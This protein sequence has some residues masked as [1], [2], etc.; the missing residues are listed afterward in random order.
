MADLP[1]FA[2]RV[3]DVEVSANAPI[4]ESLHRKYGSNI[5]FLLDFLGISDGET[6][7]SGGLSDLATA[8][9]LISNHT[10]DLQLQFT[11]VQPATDFVIGT[12]NPIQFVNQIIYLEVVT[13]S[14][15]FPTPILKY[16]SVSQIGSPLIS[17]GFNFR[18][19]VDGGA[20]QSIPSDTISGDDQMDGLQELTSP[21]NPA[22]IPYRTD[23][24]P[25]TIS[26][27]LPRRWSKI[28]SDF[29]G[30][31]L[32]NPSSNGTPANSVYQTRLYP[33]IEFDYRDT[34]SM[35]LNLQTRD[36]QAYGIVRFYRGYK[37]NVASLGI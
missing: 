16:G 24:N 12:Y 31:T 23:V 18:V 33:L 10:L 17:G 11:A 20:F 19:R 36:L 7:P 14:V 5:N 9:D 37:L 21:R 4:T 1:N 6:S 28:H 34:G 29:Q 8:V 3:N 35:Q 15:S 26:E 30:I 13:D 32:T 27:T 25:P 22:L 2:D